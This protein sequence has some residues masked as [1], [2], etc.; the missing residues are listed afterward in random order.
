M[1]KCHD[2]FR[3]QLGSRIEGERDSPAAFSG[4]IADLLLDIFQFLE[5]P[6]CMLQKN[7]AVRI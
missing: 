6:V 1:L 2:Q 3:Q 7:L 4:C 5:N